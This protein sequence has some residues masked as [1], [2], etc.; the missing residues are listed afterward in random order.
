MATWIIYLAGFIFFLI[1]FWLDAIHDAAFIQWDVAINQDERT[2]LSKI[3]HVVDSIIKGLVCFIVGLFVT[4]GAGHIDFWFAIK[5]ALFGLIIRW[6]WFDMWLNHYRG[7]ELFYV[8]NTAFL[9]KIF[10]KLP[11]LQFIIKLLAL[12][13]VILLLI[14]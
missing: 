9:D 3:F 1:Y 6:I 10:R 11:Y 8:G 14:L 12:L 13:V 7:L 4:L 5:F 2:K